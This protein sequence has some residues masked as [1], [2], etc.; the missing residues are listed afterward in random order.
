MDDS[1]RLAAKIPHNQWSFPS[2]KPSAFFTVT[3]DIW[4][5]GDRQQPKPWVFLPQEKQ[6]RLPL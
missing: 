6:S 1:K 5:V 3:N 2:L 4:T